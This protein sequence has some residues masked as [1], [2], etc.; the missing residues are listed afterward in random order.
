M[1]MTLCLRSA[2]CSWVL[3]GRCSVTGCASCRCNRSGAGSSW[4]P[5]F[6]SYF[7][8][9]SSRLE[10]SDPA[11]DATG[12]CAVAADT[13]CSL[14]KPGA[15][16]AA[17]QRNLSSALLTLREQAVGHA[18]ASH[19]WALGIGMEFARKFGEKS[20]AVLNAIGGHVHFK[21]AFFHLDPILLPLA[22]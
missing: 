9:Q 7:G 11:S 18:S 5:S 10:Q 2:A 14:S 21:R 1:A 19:H 13:N 20:N 15:A 8:T 4:T 17:N 6:F 22:R 12:A 3:T 16:N